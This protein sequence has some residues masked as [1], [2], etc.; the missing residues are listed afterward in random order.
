MNSDRYIVKFLAGILAIIV[1][2]TSVGFSANFHYCQN[3]LKN[4]DFFGEANTCHELANSATSDP[5][6]KML[7]ACHAENNLRNDANCEEGCCDNKILVVEPEDELFQTEI[8]SFE[9]INPLF[10]S[11]FVVIIFSYDAPY[12]KTPEYFN[13]KPPL[14][15]KDILIFVQSFL[16]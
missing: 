8:I 7:S 14:S 10:L 6:N 13:F 9:E 1:L 16:I 4:I 12:Y 11:A 15:G 2:I 5:C 3:E